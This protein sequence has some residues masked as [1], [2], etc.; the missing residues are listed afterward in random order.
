MTV[1][2][3]LKMP[4]PNVYQMKSGQEVLQP[5]G[6]AM[7]KLN[8]FIASRIIFLLFISSFTYNIFFSCDFV[9]SLFDLHSRRLSPLLLFSLEPND[10]FLLLDE[11]DVCYTLCKFSTN[12]ISFYLAVF[13]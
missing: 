11:K 12:S 3:D 8:S 1:I 10:H 7:G 5:A 2:H 4:L 13:V 9:A 6:T